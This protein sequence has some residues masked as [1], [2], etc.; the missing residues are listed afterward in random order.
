MSTGFSSKDRRTRRTRKL[1]YDGL[2]TLMQ[3]KPLQQISVQELTQLCDLNRS[4]FYLHYSSIQHLLS[5]MEQEMLAGLE[6]VLDQF[7]EEKINLYA[8]PFV[9]DGAM[10]Q[11]FEFL[12]QNRE[13][14]SILLGHGG[15]EQFICKVMELVRDRCLGIWTNALQHQPQYLASYF[16]TF[17]LSGCLAVVEQWLK[18]GM[19]EPPEQVA[20]MVNR[21][22]LTGASS[23]IQ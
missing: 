3:Q 17:V 21:F 1:L 16:L 9:G 10:T 14:C 2:I 18:T 23:F 8:T 11:A 22:I 6:Q 19:K 20:Q 5:E 13:F 4:T 7:E 15:D 12:S